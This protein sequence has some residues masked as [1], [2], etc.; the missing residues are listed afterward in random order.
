MHSQITRDELIKL[1]KTLADE[2][3]SSTLFVRTED[4]HSIIIGFDT[5]EIVSL[6]CGGKKGDGAIP[7]IR[8]MVKGTYHLQDK[9]PPFA[10]LGA[11]RPSRGALFSLLANNDSIAE[12]GQIQSDWVGDVLCKVLAV[13]MGPIAPVVCRDT[14]SAAGGVDSMAKVRRVVDELAAEIGDSQEA[15]RFKA[16]VSKALSERVA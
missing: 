3:R 8:K 16:E 2:K 9:A 1:V 14:I 15:E 12:E 13:Y 11:H 5:G 6:V 4:N 10:K 7:E